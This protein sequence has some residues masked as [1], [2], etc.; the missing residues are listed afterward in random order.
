MIRFRTFQTSKS[1]PQPVIVENSACS[2]VTLSDGRSLAFAEYGQSDGQP[3]FLLHGT[4]GSR[5]DFMNWDTALKS[6]GLRGIAVDRPGMGR[7]SVQ[8]E[9][10][11]LEWPHDLAQLADH[12]KIDQF[13]VMGGSGGAPHALV[14]GY[15]MPQRVRHV[16]LACSAFAVDT[17]DFFQGMS[18][19]NKLGFLLVQR[20][21]GLLN[22]VAWLQTLH[23]QNML[24]HHPQK[25]LEGL[26]QSV[27]PEDAAQLEQ[28]SPRQLQL[29]WQ[30][31]YRGGFKGMLG[32][33]RI[34]AH[35]WG[36]L[37]EAVKVPV[38]LW[39][40]MQDRLTPVHGAQKLAGRIP[41]ITAHY[42][43]AHG[44]LLDYYPGTLD[45]IL[46]SAVSEE[47]P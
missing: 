46:K 33:M 9:R 37:P 43:E 38:T 29:Q 18:F 12:L 25:V 41:H 23:M 22:A 6:Q 1:V 28:V 19:G 30:E 11:L 8:P 2:V 7:S 4:P 40:G 24:R 31:A 32:E 17:P 10:T 3:V 39:H 16:V 26:R 47:R 34:H 27:G 44:H 42:L 35:P 36:F 21:S 14:C 20:F 15:A 13:T 5:L 45:E